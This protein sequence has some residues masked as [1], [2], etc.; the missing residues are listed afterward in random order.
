VESNTGCGEALA[1]CVIAVATTRQ[2]V[3]GPDLVFHLIRWCVVWQRYYGGGSLMA[4]AFFGEVRSFSLVCLS[5]RG[6]T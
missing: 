3:C 6:R 1:R 4:V 5:A 2:P